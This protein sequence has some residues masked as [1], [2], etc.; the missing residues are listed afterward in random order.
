MHSRD[1]LSCGRGYELWLAKEALA[2]NPAI[3]TF[4]LSWG[5]PGWVGNGSYF[6]ED[7]MMYQAAFATCFQQYTGKALDFIG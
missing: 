6:S 5:V 2:R 1:D 7:N 4:A 3:R